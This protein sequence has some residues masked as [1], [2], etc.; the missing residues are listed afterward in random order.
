MDADYKRISIINNK[1]K[2]IV[3]LYVN[4]VKH[5]EV[6]KNADWAIETW[7]RGEIELSRGEGA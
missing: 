4:G 6:K 7:G 3:I 2:D 1:S 5:A